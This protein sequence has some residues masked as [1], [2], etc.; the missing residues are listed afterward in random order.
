MA[1]S[2]KEVYIETIQKGIAAADTIK[3]STAKA[4]AYA[5]LALAMVPLIEKEKSN[6]E[7][8]KGKDAIKKGNNKG[9]NKKSTEV[10]TP[11][12]TEAPLSADPIELEDE[13]VQ[14]VVENVEE[15]QATEVVEEAVTEEVAAEE[16]VEAVEEEVPVLEV[17]EEV[18]DG[19]VVNDGLAEEFEGFDEGS[20]NRLRQD[21]ALLA[22]LRWYMQ[23]L[24]ENG[25]EIIV[26]YVPLWSDNQHQTLDDI[27]L[28]NVQSFVTFMKS[29]IEAAE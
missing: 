18:A 19:E 25:A 17:E 5:S 28:D 9:R 23:L 8:A 6:G 10:A 15:V 12:A 13:Q 14:E 11:V 20:L 3:D 22:D 27:T 29:Q 24:A 26:Q 21:A 2:I 4:N 1:I 16:T 7:E